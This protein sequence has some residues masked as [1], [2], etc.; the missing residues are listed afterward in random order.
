MVSVLNLVLAFMP[1]VGSV[2][3]DANRIAGT[4]REEQNPLRQ[5]CFF[6]TFPFD[7]RG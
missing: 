2:C 6:L 3:G 7:F 5:V 4:S 1:I